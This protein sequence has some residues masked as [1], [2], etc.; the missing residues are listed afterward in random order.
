MAGDTAL[1]L[2]AEQGHAEVCLLLLQSGAQVDRVTGSDQRTA[3][4][5]AAGA[6]RVEAARVLLEWGADPN[7]VSGANA[8]SEM[9]PL[10]IAA[11]AGHPAMVKL[12][13]QYNAKPDLV[14]RVR[15][16][17]L[18]IALLLCEYSAC[19]VYSLAVF[20]YYS[21]STHVCFK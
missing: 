8:S 11:Y 6:G 3:L 17:A 5:R 14:V 1:A 7:R 20:I 9:S 4:M 16:C 19:T 2:A 18:F 15:A 12:L 13:V 21:Y 10:S